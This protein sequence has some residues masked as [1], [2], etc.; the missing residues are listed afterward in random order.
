MTVTNKKPTI[1]TAVLLLAISV[2]AQSAPEGITSGQ[3]LQKQAESVTTDIDTQALKKMLDDELEMVLIDIRTTDEV[4]NMGGTIDAIQNSVIPRGWLE[5]RASKV[6][7][8]KDTPI[9]VY[10]G[11]GIRS[12]LAAKTLQDMGYTNVKNYS[13]GFLGWRKAG[14]PIK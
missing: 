7:Q 1:I 13:T 6:A 12:P 11:A 4:S 10:C 9:V 5:F 8:N 3:Q 2:S 14:L